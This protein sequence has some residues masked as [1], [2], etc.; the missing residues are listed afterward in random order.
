MVVVEE[1]GTPA[2]LRQAPQEMRRERGRAAPRRRGTRVCWAAQTS[3]IY[4]GRGGAAPPPRFPPLEVAASPR[5]HLGGGQGGERGGRTT[6]W[7]L[8]PSEPRVCPLPL[9][10]APWALVGGGAHQPT[11][12]WSPPTLGPCSPSGLVAPLGGPPGPS[13][14]SRYVTD[15]PR[16]F[17]GDQNRTSHI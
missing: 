6:R 11:W 1:R 12:G 14:W 10:L 15:K 8:G 4:R 5:S 7:A 17:S 3:S 16:N 13:R 9:S 2:G